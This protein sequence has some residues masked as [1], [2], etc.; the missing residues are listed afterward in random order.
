MPLTSRERPENP[1][2][3]LVLMLQRAR[4]RAREVPRSN[5]LRW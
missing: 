2:L 1:Q 5:T 4:R 3:Q